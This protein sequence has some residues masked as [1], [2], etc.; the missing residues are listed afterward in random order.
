VKNKHRQTRGAFARSVIALSALALSSIATVFAAEQLITKTDG[1]PAD[2]TLKIDK[3][4]NG[5]NTTQNSESSLEFVRDE[6]AHAAG[7]QE[8]ISDSA[9]TSTRRN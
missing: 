8:L 5:Q 7:A 1:K 2:M 6:R 3:Y 4:K 9:T